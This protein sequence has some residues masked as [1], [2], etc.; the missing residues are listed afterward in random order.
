MCRLS[1]TAITKGFKN[2]NPKFYERKLYDISF[3]WQ[4]ELRLATQ[5]LGVG[6]AAETQTVSKGHA[7]TDHSLYENP[8]LYMLPQLMSSW[9]VTK[10]I[11]Y[12]EYSV[13]LRTQTVS[14][15][16]VETFLFESQ[17]SFSWWCWRKGQRITTVWRIHCLGT[18]RVCTS[19]CDNPSRTCWDNAQSSFKPTE[20]NSYI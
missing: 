8:A 14:P 4:Q 15:I 16:F 2:S 18:V 17:M 1:Q 20:L 13:W 3:G 11:T 5:F 10:V 6:S 12:L 7:F 9:W 19:H